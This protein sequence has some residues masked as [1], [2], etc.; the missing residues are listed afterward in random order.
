M[1]LLARV[2]ACVSIA[3]M[4]T[5]CS[6]VD[7]KYFD[8][9]IGTELYSSPLPEATQLQETYINFIC[10]QAGLGFIETLTVPQCTSSLSPRDW[11]VFVQAGMND[12]DQRCDAY[13]SWLDSRRRWTAPTLQQIGDTQTATDAILLATSVG[14][15]PIGI[16]AAAFGLARNTFT[17]LN[18]RLLLE[19]NHSTVQSIVMSHQNLY[20]ANI[21]RQV[22][23]NRPTAIYALRSYL[24]I[25]MPFTIE[26]EINTTITAFERGG[27]GALK[28]PPLIDASVVSR[29]IIRSAT[30]PISPPF[31]RPRVPTCDPRFGP[32]DPRFGPFE[33]GLR[34]PDIKAYQ[35]LV[36]VTEDG[37]LGGQGSPTRQ[38][39]HKYLVKLGEK[40]ETDD[41][42]K[43]T[44]R[45][46]AI[47][48][49]EIRAGKSACAP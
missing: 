19:V 33:P 22:I 36:C 16:V 8:Q 48:R 37:R 20:R 45:D 28:R 32:C 38:A 40:A 39:I 29:Q 41:P 42:D 4:L 6:S 46:D 24:R 5:A 23:D 47:L 14:P 44:V 11:A 2:S 30:A 17:N 7:G 18:S 12:I 10:Q 26:T 3:L 13:L 1:R 49:R 34:D 43:I 9:G 27:P 31:V 25:C 35:K 21:L 15:L